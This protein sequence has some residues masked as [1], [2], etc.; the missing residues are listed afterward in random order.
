MFKSGDFKSSINPFTLKFKDPDLEQNYEKTRSESL[1]GLH[2]GKI[3]ISIVTSIMSLLFIYM[4]YKNYILGNFDISR[5]CVIVIIVL[6][7]SW[8]GEFLLHLFK[9]LHFLAGFCFIILESWAEIEVAA[10]ALST[11]AVSPGGLSGFFNMLF[12]GTFYSKNWMTATL[13]Q[14]IGYIIIGFLGWTTFSTQMDTKRLFTLE[15][16]LNV[17]IF[18]TAFIYYYV[19]SQQRLTAYTKWQIEKV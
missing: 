3:I 8:V 9:P 10:V 5:R 16:S 2:P 4:A 6:E 12:V 15:I 18:V 17:S 1:N 11:F 14:G 13:A 19:E 7:L